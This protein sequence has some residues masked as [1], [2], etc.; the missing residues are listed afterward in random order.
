[1]LADPVAIATIS[2]H[3][4]YV[5]LLR[6]SGKH[7]RL[8]TDARQSPLSPGI[9]LCSHLFYRKHRILISKCLVN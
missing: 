3:L 7:V 5:D 2:A 1:M 4:R 9:M 8:G 6:K